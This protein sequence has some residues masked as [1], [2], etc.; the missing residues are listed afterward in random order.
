[1][2]D[3]PV[4]AKSGGSEAKERICDL[5]SEDVKERAGQVEII[6]WVGL[7][8]SWVDKGEEWR[9]NRAGGW[10]VSTIPVLTTD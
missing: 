6:Q 1:M 5:G 7:L 2:N 4:Q 8:R 9:N 10:A 3:L